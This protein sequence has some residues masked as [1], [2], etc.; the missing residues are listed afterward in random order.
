MADE[1]NK[2]ATLNCAPLS[3]FITEINNT[4]K[5]NAKDVNVVMP[6]NNLTKYSNNSEKI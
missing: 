3:N 1:K 2:Q 4:Q 6:M 5:D